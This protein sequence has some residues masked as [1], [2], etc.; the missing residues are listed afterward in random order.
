MGDF[1]TYFIDN[2]IL[3]T[4]LLFTVTYLIMNGMTCRGDCTKP[5]LITLI[6]ILV[7]YLFCEMPS[8]SYE[9]MSSIPTYRIVPKSLDTMRKYNMMNPKK[10]NIF[11]KHSD[12]RNGYRLKY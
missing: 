10:D 6:I 5:V 8:N 11:L 7:A 3:I 4:I 12:M 2:I 9:Q 1:N